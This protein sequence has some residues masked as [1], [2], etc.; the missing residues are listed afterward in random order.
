VQKGVYATIQLS[1][2]AE[3]SPTR[4]IGDKRMSEKVVLSQIRVIGDKTTE[5]ELQIVANR[6]RHLKMP[7]KHKKGGVSS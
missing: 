5:Q 4:G 3:L 7:P 2:R 6:V 1:E